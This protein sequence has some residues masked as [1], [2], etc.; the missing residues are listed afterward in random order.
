MAR[1]RRTRSR[2]SIAGHRAPSS[3]EISQLPCRPLRT[4]TLF[5]A[6]RIDLDRDDAVALW[7]AKTHAKPRPLPFDGD[8]DGICLDARN[9]R[10]AKR[11]SV[12]GFLHRSLADSRRHARTRMVL[13]GFEFQKRTQVATPC[14]SRFAKHN[15]VS[16]ER[17]RHCSSCEHTSRATT[18]RRETRSSFQVVQSIDRWRNKG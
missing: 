4:R 3:R 8:V 10:L 15:P 16:A 17:S 2:G 13:V 5:Q 6:R 12:A 11:A 14:S 7:T 1:P 18:C 9:R